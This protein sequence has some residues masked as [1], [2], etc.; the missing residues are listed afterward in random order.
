MKTHDG[1]ADEEQAIR[2]LAERQRTGSESPG[3]IQHWIN[4]SSPT[5]NTVTNVKLEDVEKQWLGRAF[6]KTSD[7]MG[8]SERSSRASEKLHDAS[9]S[10]GKQRP[11]NWTPVSPAERLKLKTPFMRD[12][13]DDRTMNEYMKK[14]LE[15]LQETNSVSGQSA[16]SDKPSRLHPT[17]AAMYRYYEDQSLLTKSTINEAAS[18]E[19]M[20]SM[21]KGQ[22]DSFEVDKRSQ[23]DSSDV[24]SDIHSMSAIPS[25]QV[26]DIA[27]DSMSTHDSGIGRDMTYSDSVSL[28]KQRTRSFR[29]KSLKDR[30]Q[31]TLSPVK[32]AQEINIQVPQNWRQFFNTPTAQER[33]RMELVKREFSQ[34]KMSRHSCIPPIS[35]I[36]DDV[37][38]LPAEEGLRLLHTVRVGEKISEEPEER[39]QIQPIPGRLSMHTQNEDTGLSN[40]GIIQMQWTTGVPGVVSKETPEESSRLPTKST[41]KSN[42]T[43]LYLPQLH[44]LKKPEKGQY[45]ERCYHSTFKRFIILVLLA[46]HNLQCV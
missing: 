12:I 27:T 18:E 22:A 40:F 32:S 33:R 46:Q 43:S 3:N 45:S 29:E 23:I 44:H 30:G 37:P 5:A 20:G 39:H 17:Q 34:G 9:F 2:N 10:S 11:N 42:D 36:S 16:A 38:L 24:D 15:A 7:S 31:P 21:K 35:Y 28:R 41:I 13:S 8:V 19:E 6:Q 4:S 14:H 1:T 25:S 26:T